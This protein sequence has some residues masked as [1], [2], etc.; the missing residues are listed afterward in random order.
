MQAFLIDDSL[1]MKPHW[2]GVQKV[3]EALSYIVKETDPN[4]IDLYFTISLDYEQNSKSTTGL[5][6]MIKTRTLQSNTDINLRLSAILNKYK[7]A[8]AKPRSLL[9]LHNK[10]VRPLTLYILTDGVWESEC[11]PER[12]IKSLVEKMIE[13]GQ[14]KLQVGLQFISFG[15]NSI[16]LKRMERLDS[17]LG[18]PMY[19]RTSSIL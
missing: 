4:G 15:N 1:S 5:L 3:F 12:L 14:D 8:L 16:G 10:P 18:L 2:K 19:V 13:L 11:N 6:R 7:A 9:L 17:G